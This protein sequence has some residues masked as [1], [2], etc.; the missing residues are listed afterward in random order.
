MSGSSKAQIGVYVAAAILLVVGGAYL[1]RGGEER[2]GGGG[3][4]ALDGSGSGDSAE[5]KPARSGGSLYVHVAG[6]VRRPGMY[7]L[8]DG[9]RV[10]AAVRCAGGLTRRADLTAFNLAAAVRDGQQVIVPRIGQGGAGAAGGVAAGR[11]PGAA[12]GGGSAGGGGKISLATATREQ[13]DGIDGIG[14][15]LAARIIAYRDQHRGFKSVEELGE[16]EGIGEKRLAGL[17]RSVRP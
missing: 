1:L 6:A 4:V 14:P 7:R 13:L 8:P 3:E 11:A 10:A 16:V 5:T 15:K 9:A 12:R 2:S 17:R